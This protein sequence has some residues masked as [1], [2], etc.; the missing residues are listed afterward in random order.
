VGVIVLL[1]LIFGSV[2]V[3]PSGYI[4]I[5]TTFGKVTGELQPGV[6]LKWPIVQSVTAMNVQVQNDSSN[7]SAATNDLQNVSTN[8]TLNYHLDHAQVDNIFVNLTANYQANL[9]SPTVS[10]VTKA[11]TADYT[12]SQLLTDRAQVTDAIEQG[13][14]K[15]LEPRGI[16]VDQVSLT[17][18]QFSSQF[19]QAVEAKNAAQQSAEQAQY[20][21]Q[22]AQLDAQAN[23]VQDAALTPSILEQQAIAK[24]NG[25]MPTTVSGSA[26]IFSIPVG[27]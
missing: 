22:K 5:T 27:Q 7:E 4:G 11:V 13:L 18:F 2:A 24:W 6:N 19:T 21:L 17:N 20:N 3:V 25:V 16:L 23:Q 12:A 15:V 26:S 1:I 8:V 10:E 14:V 9:I